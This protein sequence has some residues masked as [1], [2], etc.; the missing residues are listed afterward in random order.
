MPGRRLLEPD[1]V[2]EHAARRLGASVLLV[3][4]GLAAGCGTER[5]DL[6]EL[7]PRE[8]EP[9]SRLSYP[10]VGLSVSVPRTVPVQRRRAPGVFKATA[11]QWLVSAFAYRRREQLPRDRRELEQARRRLVR[12]TRRRDRRYRLIR[13]RT[14]RVAGTRAIELVGDQTLSRARMRFRSLHLFKGRGEYVIELAAPPREARAATRRLFRPVI[15]SLR[16]SGKIRGR[17]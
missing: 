1:P 14:T 4:A 5:A 11:A 8:G 7:H 2:S 13:S 16:V 17:R 9:V 6:P 3:L 15:R 10:R 12:E